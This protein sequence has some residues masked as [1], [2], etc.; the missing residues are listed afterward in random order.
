MQW[1]ELNDPEDPILDRLAMEHNLHPL[2]IEDC[3]HRNQNAKIEP[4]G[5]YLFLV[6]KS[7][8]MDEECVIELGDL[9]IFIGPEY[10][11]TV[12][13]QKCEAISDAV[14]R[15][16]SL[17]QELRPDQVL[18]RIMDWVVDS[19]TPILDK[20]SDRID[21]M[22]D[23]A[24]VETGSELLQTIF[25]M[26]RA[27]IQ[28]RRVMAHT[29]DLVGHLLRNDSSL[30][31]ADMMPFLRDVYDHLVRNL[32]MVEVYRDLLTGTTELYLTSVANRTNQ[33]MKVLTVVGTV[34]TPAL[35]VSGIYGMNI[36]TLPFA[37]H[38]QSFVIIL[39]LIFGVSGFLL[40]V[41]KRFGWM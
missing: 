35:I 32:D 26:K 6:L 38:P 8:Q 12:Q 37:R 39:G 23:R 17:R 30:I 31:K 13:E 40:A 24:L 41:I 11:I 2:H 29:R 15:V 21:E 3:R 7:V 36:D 22:E 33:V 34:A 19:Y 9:D 10:V 16:R 18:Y 28:L 4:W 1:H 14:T 25:G 20:L 27:L 5:D